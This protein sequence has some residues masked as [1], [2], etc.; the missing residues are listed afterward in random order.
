MLLK[1]NKLF[2]LPELLAGSFSG[3]DR[4]EIPYNIL[5]LRRV[6]QRE[7]NGDIELICQ[8]KDGPEQKNGWIEFPVDNRSKKDILYGWFKLQINKDI[9]T[10]YN[11]SFT[12]GGKTCPVCGDNMFKSMEPK[13][14]NLA[15]ANSK[16]P[17]QS[18][19]WRCSNEDCEYKEGV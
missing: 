8:A 14:T 3:L 7:D 15:N 4:L 6:Q 19:Y 18:E 11:S 12:F 16:L 17:H 5:I 10:I 2:E 13:V 9:E 1:D